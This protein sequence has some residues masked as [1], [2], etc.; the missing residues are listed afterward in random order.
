M[1]EL[2]ANL[3]EFQQCGYL[4]DTVIVVDDG[5]VK[6]HSVI[7]AAVSPVFKRAL[8]S[9]HQPVQ[10]TIVLPGMQLVIVNVIIQFVYTGKI[11]FS[12][13]ECHNLTKIMSAIDELQIK[14]HIIRFRY[15][16]HMQTFI[17][18]FSG[19]QC[20]MASSQYYVHSAACCCRP[21]SVACR[22]VYRSV[23]VV[24]PAKMDQPIEIS[25]G[26]RTRLGP[27]NHVLDGV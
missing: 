22:F 3:F 7:L 2:T 18:E 15:L 27:R 14:L 24:S 16:F 25:F 21:S 17:F 12:K 1:Q 5:H 23:T 11:V 19:T 26:L 10:H 20:M 6:A 8:R 9:T 4:C 13:S